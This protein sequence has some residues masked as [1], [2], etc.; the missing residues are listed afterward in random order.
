MVHFLISTFGSLH[1]NNYTLEWGK[2]STK[3]INRT[4]CR[5]SHEKVLILDSL[6]LS[7]QV[8]FHILFHASKIIGSFL[9]EKESL[10]SILDGVV[11][12]FNSCSWIKVTVF[13]IGYEILEYFTSK[14]YFYEWSKFLLILCIYLNCSLMIWHWQAF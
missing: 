13:S 12:V 5:S 10:C 2:W 14:F 6:C 3:T 9:F 4:T 7:L 11:L 8:Q 1:V